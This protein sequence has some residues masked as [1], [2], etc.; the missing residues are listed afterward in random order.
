MVQEAEDYADE[1]KKIRDRTDSR[2][3]LESYLY[4][5]KNSLTGDDGSGV[6]NK[7]RESDKEVGSFLLLCCSP[8]TLHQSV[9]TLLLGD[10]PEMWR[11]VHE[12]NAQG[13]TGH[14]S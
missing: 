13:E 11:G 2:N 6:A 3:S 14:R 5:V 7:M 10:Y 9:G 4:N 8:V 12:F 1:D